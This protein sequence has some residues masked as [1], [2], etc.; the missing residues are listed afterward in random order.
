MPWKESCIVDERLKFVGRL[1]EGDK[2]AELCREFE[3]S[4]KTGYKI[5]SRYQQVGI[6]G[7]TDRSRRPVRY[8]NQLPLQLEATI[9]LLK[10]Q[11]PSWGAPKI[12]EILSRKYPEVRTPAKSTV[13]AVLDRQ[14]LVKRRKR[15]RDKRYRYPLTITDFSSRYVLAGDGLE[16]TKEMYAFTVFE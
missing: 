3:I 7:L 4:R 11:K 15:K 12:R 10:K 6:Q 14:G 13:H 2:M 9:V 5:W 16:T 8:A 1:L